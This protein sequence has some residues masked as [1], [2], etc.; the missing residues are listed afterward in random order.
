MAANEHKNLSDVNRHNPKGLETAIND[1]I[2]TKDIG[3]GAGLS[4]GVLQWTP[5]SQLKT[6]IVSIKGFTTGNGSTYEYAQEMTDAQSPFEHNVDY[7]NAT[8]GAA[9][10]DVSNIFRAGG[11]LVHSD[12]TINKISGWLVGN[13]PTV[14]TLAICKVTPVNNNAAQ[15]TPVLLDEIAISCTSND[16]LQRISELTF[17]NDGLLD[18]DI[19]FAMVKTDVNGRVIFFNTTMELKYNN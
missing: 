11:Y 3:T 13:A 14:A 16:K 1:S 15:L 19:V 7:G 8:V 4:D 5:K 2:L 9:T 17:N 12:C 6:T 18:G 10:L